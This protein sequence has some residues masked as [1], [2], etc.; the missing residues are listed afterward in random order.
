MGEPPLFLA[1]SVFF[2]IKEAI[3]AAR[4]DSGV[5]PEFVLDTPATCARI[6]MACED[7]ITKQVTKQIICKTYFGHK[8]KQQ[9]VAVLQVACVPFFAQRADRITD[10]LA[11]Q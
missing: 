9:N 5:S 4:L 8:C 6:R 1:A 3:K 2:A 10:N 11:P 7:L